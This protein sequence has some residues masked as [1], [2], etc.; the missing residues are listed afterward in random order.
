MLLKCRCKKSFLACSST[1]KFSMLE[2]S[3]NT[4][5]WLA[6]DSVVFFLASSSRPLSFLQRLLPDFHN[7]QLILL[8]L[9]DKLQYFYRCKT[10]FNSYFTV[11]NVF[12]PSQL[13]HRRLLHI[14]YFVWLTVQNPFY[15]HR[16]IKIEYLHLKSFDQ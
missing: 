11:N 1:I 7:H 10:Q 2:R 15:H 6:V 4:Y 9:E 12:V 13:L 8:C 3:G 14:L 16:S 5:T